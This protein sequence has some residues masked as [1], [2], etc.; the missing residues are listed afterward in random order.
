MGDDLELRSIMGVES[1]HEKSNL[2]YQML[3]ENAF[4]SIRNSIC[5]F[6]KDIDSVLFIAISQGIETVFSVISPLSHVL[7]N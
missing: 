5:K 3:L 7:S 1:G 2:G 6:H 4:F